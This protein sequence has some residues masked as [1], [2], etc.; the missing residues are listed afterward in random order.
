MTRRPRAISDVWLALGSV[1]IIIGAWKLAERSFTSWWP[2]LTHSFTIAASVIWP[3]AI[4]VAVTL[5]IMAVR[6]GRYRPKGKL[7]YRSRS[8]HVISGVCGGMGAYFGID[9]ALIRILWV[10]LAAVSLGTVLIV[11]LICWVIIPLE[12]VNG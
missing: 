8:S 3:L 7:L 11:Y 12:P 6:S 2:F 5:V 9:P 4:V 1:L 10:V